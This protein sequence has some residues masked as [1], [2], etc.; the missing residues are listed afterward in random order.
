MS[1]QLKYVYVDPE[2]TSKTTIEITFN[3]DESF[4]DVVQ[5]FRKF[6]LAMGYS[7]YDVKKALGE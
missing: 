3:I 2:T 4:E 5:H 1:A 6:S 7:V